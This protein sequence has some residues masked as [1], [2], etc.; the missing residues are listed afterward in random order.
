MSAAILAQAIILSLG[1]GALLGLVVGDAIRYAKKQRH[2]N[3]VF[4]H[5]ERE[6]VMVEVDD[7]EWADYYKPAA[8]QWGDG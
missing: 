4:D 8:E 2:H 1:I 7:S 6:F 5:E 3:I